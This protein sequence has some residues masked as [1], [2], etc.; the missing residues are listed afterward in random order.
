MR[1][2][3]VIDRQR[4]PGFVVLLH[5]HRAADIRKRL[6]LRGRSDSGS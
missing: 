1:I 2:E 3:G 4:V 5:H 6:G